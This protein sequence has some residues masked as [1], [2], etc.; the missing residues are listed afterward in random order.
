[1]LFIN[2][3]Q[4]P[5]GA[6]EQFLTQWREVNATM[7]VRPGYL[8]HR[9]HRALVDTTRYRF[10]NVAEWASADHWRDAHDDRFR[11]LVTR[12]EWARFPSTPGLYDVIHD[13]G[14]LAAGPR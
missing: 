9:L 8:G 10:V 3:F 5:A 2:S 1:M 4:V 11:A 13:G 12:P 7:S 6:D 14:A